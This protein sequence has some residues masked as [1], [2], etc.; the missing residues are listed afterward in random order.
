MVNTEKIGK[1]DES[2]KENTMFERKRSRE[3]NKIHRDINK[4]KEWGKRG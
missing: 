2:R 4:Q 1:E 3:K